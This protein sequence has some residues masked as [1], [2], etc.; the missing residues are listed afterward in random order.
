MTHSL[1]RNRNVSKRLWY[2]A[3]QHAAALRRHCAPTEQKICAQTGPE[4]GLNADILI[5]IV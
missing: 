1:M 4:F 2:Y 5:F 3:G